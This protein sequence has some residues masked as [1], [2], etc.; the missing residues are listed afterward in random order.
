MH[1]AFSARWRIRA[2]SFLK[3]P[4]SAKFARTE[5][6]D[7]FGFGRFLEKKKDELKKMSEN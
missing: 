4:N 3:G 2:K 1:D 6:S 5:N 7:E